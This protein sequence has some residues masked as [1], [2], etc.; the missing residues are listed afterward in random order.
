ML[1]IAIFVVHSCRENV[2][3][4]G[5]GAG[6]DIGVFRISAGTD[7]GEVHRICVVRWSGGIAKCPHTYLIIRL[8]LKTRKHIVFRGDG[9]GQDCPRIRIRLFV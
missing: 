5:V 1:R 7:R 4:V 3:I 2:S 9:I 6:A 8:R